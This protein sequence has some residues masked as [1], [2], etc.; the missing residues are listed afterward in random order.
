[1]NIN[2]LP[3][4]LA[5]EL[6]NVEYLLNIWRTRR[7]RN[8][9]LRQRLKGKRKKKMKRALE[10]GGW[11]KQQSAETK[12]NNKT[13]KVNTEKKRVQQITKSTR[14]NTRAAEGAQESQGA[15]SIGSFW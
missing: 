5:K 11:E 15:G 3:V 10:M 6:K 12:Q 9:R 4:L 7:I 8:I 14:Q 1:M 13:T 2:F